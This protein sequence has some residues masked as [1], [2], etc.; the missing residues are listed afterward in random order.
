MTDAE[1]KLKTDYT[2]YRTDGTLEHGSVMWPK[3]PKLADFDALIP[4]IV[5]CRYYERV[6]V[7]HERRYTD[8]FVDEEGGLKDLPRNDIATQIYRCNWM[9]QY[10]STRAESLP[11]ISG[12]AVLFHRRV[13]F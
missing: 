8:M 12:V 4:P 6:R 10:P 7:L 1:T 9:T 11:H 2:I 3:E 13:W 5:G